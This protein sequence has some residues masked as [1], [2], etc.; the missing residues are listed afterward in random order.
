MGV[1]GVLEERK[2]CEWEWEWDDLGDG[3][4]AVLVTMM[5]NVSGLLSALREA[6]AGSVHTLASVFLCGIHRG[7]RCG[8]ATGLKRGCRGVERGGL[9]GGWLKMVVERCF[10]GVV[11]V[12]VVVAVDVLLEG[13]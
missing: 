11:D 1:D 6:I 13:L 8:R 2:L 5:G 12:T 4:V 3:L 7:R 9:G 10:E